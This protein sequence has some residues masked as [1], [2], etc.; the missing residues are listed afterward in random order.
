MSG[1][2]IPGP[3]DGGVTW[4]TVPG[5][6]RGTMENT[7]AVPKAITMSDM[8]LA[9]LAAIARD[10]ASETPKRAHGA[11]LL[12]RG[13]VPKGARYALDSGGAQG[14]YGWLNGSPTMCGLGF[15]GY[16]YLAELAQRSEY[17]SPSETTATEMTREWGQ[18]TGGSES[19]RKE[20]TQ[21]FEDFG[22]RE[23]F[24]LMG[25]ND[26]FFGRA[27]LY[28]VMKGQDTDQ[29]RKLP[30]LVDEKTITKG[31]LKGFKSI[32]PVWTT[33]YSFN[34]IDPTKP[35]FY[36]PDWWYVMGKQT[37][38]T[39]LLT[40]IGRP[41][42]DILKPSYNFSGLS[43]SQ[44]IEPYVQRWLKTVDSVNR[45]LSNFSTSGIATNM[46]ATLTGGGNGEDVMKRAALFNLM[47]DSRGLLLLDKNSEEFF[48]FNTPLSGLAELQAQ[49]QE[50][51]AAPT[52][53]PLVKLTG[54]TPSGL[55]ASSDG[56]IKV[57]YDFVG[58]EQENQYTPNLMV[59]ARMLQLHLWGKIDETIKWEWTPLDSPTDKEESE[60]R[61]ADAE[62]D[63]AYVDRGV[64]SA[65][66]VRERLRSDP[67]SG[68]TGIKG[69][70]PDLALEEH[71][72][73]QAGAEADAERAEGAAG[74]QHERDKELERIKAKN[75][76][77]AKK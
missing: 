56:E 69:D 47:R 64:L 31:S 7:P 60:M 36:R 44:M 5:Y 29:R 66:E 40:F 26:G 23:N 77:A 4:V 41:V 72:L 38:A 18:F 22:V 33:P 49:A 34:S 75:K 67:K 39:R 17:R 57:W 20:L 15:P 13:V 45:L 35:D 21:A 2:S 50:H 16:Q 8:A 46:Q 27:Q 14:M 32:E 3:A 25:I 61:K 70:A 43:L 68:Y 52:H 73:G 1:A 12:P 30:L 62:R 48:Q 51:M 9:T 37:H 24:R 63:G 55:N 71:E 76:P 42:P 74:N 59:I 65:D 28:V 10:T 54:I 53:I 19:K 6:S 11:P 58:A